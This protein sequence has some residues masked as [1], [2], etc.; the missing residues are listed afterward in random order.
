LF[1]NSQWYVV[2]VN[3]NGI[4]CINISVVIISLSCR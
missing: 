3:T 1:L 4:V 2:K